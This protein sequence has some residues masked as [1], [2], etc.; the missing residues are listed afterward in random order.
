VIGIVKG[1]GGFLQ[2]YSQPGQGSTFSAYLR[3]RARA[4][5]PGWCIERK[6][7]F[8]SGETILLVDDEP[9]SGRWRARCCAGLNFKPLTATDGA[10]VDTGDRNIGPN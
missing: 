2:V 6:L 10:M 9:R 4:L 5:I 1:H 8:A 7:T 3:R